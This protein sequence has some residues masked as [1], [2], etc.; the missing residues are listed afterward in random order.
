NG[1]P[2]CQGTGYRGRMGIHEM[3]MIDD[4]VRNRIMQRGNSNQIRSASRTIRSLRYDGA[5]KILRGLTSFDE[6]LRVTQE[7]VL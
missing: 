7:D 2:G 4:E 5:Q 6:V 1:C 3:L